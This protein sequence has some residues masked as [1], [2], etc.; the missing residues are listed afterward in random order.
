M[1]T[2]LFFALCVGALGGYVEEKCRKCGKPKITLQG[3][4][5]L[6]AT[7]GI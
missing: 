6:D 1:K 2:I 5:P 3:G 7:D 4:V